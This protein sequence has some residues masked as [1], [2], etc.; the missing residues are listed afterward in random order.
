MTANVPV[1]LL[2]EVNNNI[3]S[4]DKSAKKGTQF[5]LVEESYIIKEFKKQLRSRYVQ[6][7]CSKYVAVS[8]FNW[9]K[10]YFWG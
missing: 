5:S 10:V 1:K 7:I 6:Y 8:W 9:G 4:G 3:F 2:F